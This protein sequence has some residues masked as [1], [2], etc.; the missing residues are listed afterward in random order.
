M[1]PS[2]KTLTKF[3][4]T[5]I[6]WS[7][8]YA[9]IILKSLAYRNQ[10]GHEITSNDVTYGFLWCVVWLACMIFTAAIRVRIPVVAAKFHNVYD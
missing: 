3:V 10:V 2:K 9:S 7:N 8:T 5:L 1:S 6:V 4:F